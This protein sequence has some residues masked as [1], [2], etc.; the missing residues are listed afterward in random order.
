MLSAVKRYR[1]RLSGALARYFPRTAEYLREQGSLHSPLAPA[2]KPRTGKKSVK[3]SASKAVT[4][5]TK[6]AGAGR[7]RATPGLLLPEGAKLEPRA[8]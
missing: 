5:K 1:F 4:D 6:P 2:S 3:A 7:K 8:P